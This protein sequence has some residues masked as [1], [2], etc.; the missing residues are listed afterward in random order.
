[1]SEGVTYQIE[2]I[3]SNPKPTSNG[4]PAFI[5]EYIAKAKPILF[6]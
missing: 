5:T 2:E 1:M 3:D 6:Y 4:V